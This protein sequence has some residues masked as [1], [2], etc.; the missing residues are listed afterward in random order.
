VTSEGKNLGTLVRMQILLPFAYAA[1]FIFFILKMKFFDCGRL[2]RTQLTG[3]F[4]LKIIAG[5]IG[6]YIYHYYYQLGDSQVYV[7]GGKNLF[8]AFITNSAPGKIPGWKASFEDVFFNNNRIMIYVNFF[9]HFVSFNNAF[10]HIIFFC[11]LSFVGLTS[12]LKAFYKHF[13]DKKYVLVFG[14]YLIP[15]VVFWTSGIYKEALAIS[16]IGLLIYHSD[17]GLTK[18]A[19]FFSIIIMIG[20]AVLLYFL[21]VHIF[22]SLIPFLLINA[23][24]SRTKENYFMLK[25]IS[26]GILLVLLCHFISRIN[27]RTNFYHLISDRRAKA[28]SE[29]KGGRFLAS[30]KNFIRVDYF[31]QEDLIALSDSTFKIAKGSNFMSWPLENM[32]DTSFIFNSNDTVV[33]KLLYAV[34]PANS[35]IELKKMEP[36]F[37]DFYSNIPVAIWNVLMKPGIKGVKNILQL[38]SWFE[39]IFLLLLLIITVFFFNKKIFSQKKIIVFSILFALTQFALIGLT[40][41]VIGAIVRYKVTAVPFLV[42]VCLLCIDKEQIFKTVRKF[43][44]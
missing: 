14:L 26:A 44:T 30:N 18:T 41:P 2:T 4:A 3:L 31:K 1:I 35:V 16:C 8:D 5:I 42:I 28:I 9:I 17:F 19:N 40:N 24:I 12:L 20:A 29:A 7:Q 39:N 21:K 25:Y 38:C 11:F 22:F 33:Y 13:P 27:E 10:V 6:Y 43:K 23:F 32:K 37:S 34:S 15:S 36:T